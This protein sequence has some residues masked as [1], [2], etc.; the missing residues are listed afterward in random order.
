VSANGGTCA[1]IACTTTGFTGDAGSCTCAPNFYGQVTYTLFGTTVGC[2]QCPLGK[3]SSTA[4][5]GCTAIVCSGAFIGTA[6]A[7]TC[8]P[9]FAGAPTYTAGVLSGCT[10][11]VAGF[12]S[13]AGTNTN[14]VKISCPLP[15][16][17]DIYGGCQC[18]PGWSGVVAYV[19]GVAQGC[20]QCPTGYYAMQLGSFASCVAIACTGAYAGLAGACTCAAGFAGSATYLNGVAAGCTACPIGKWSVEGNGNTCTASLCAA[21]YS[22]VP[23]QCTCAAGYKGLASG[24]L[25]TY[26]GGLPTGCTA[27]AAGSW[28]LPTPVTTPAGGNVCKFIDCP[29]PAYDGNSG[30]CTCSAGFWGTV[31]WL[32]GAAT[33]CAACPLGYWSTAGAR[34]V[35]TAVVCGPG[36]VGS[37]GLCTCA[38]GYYGSVNYANGMTSGCT[39]C[40]IGTWSVAGSK[41]CSGV[42]C[43]A[44]AFSGLAGVCM[45]S[46]NYFGTVL[47][48]TT[49]G[50]TSGCKA[51]AANTYTV[52]GNGL[53]CLAVP[54]PAPAYTGSAGACT[55]SAGWSG[56]V[57]Y[58][59]GAV[60]GC[61][62]CPTGYWSQ[63]GNAQACGLIVCTAT[64]YTKATGQGL[65]TCAVGY[66]GVVSYLLGVPTGCTACAAGKWS[67]GNGAACT[68]VPCNNIDYIGTAGSCVCAN[69]QSG[70]AKTDATGVWTGCAACPVGWWSTAGNYQSCTPAPCT[71]GYSGVAGSCM[72]DNGLQGTSLFVN[73]QWTG[74]Q[75]CPTGFW[76]VPAATATCTAITCPAPGYTGVSGYC[77]CSTGYSGT[78]S[79][80]GG[81]ATG[82]ALVSG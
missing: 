63:P 4:S 50:T 68:P 69:G 31:V 37:D 67:N 7:C 73:G 40:P 61:S 18:A 43:L 17:T 25:V 34:S 26:T 32:N 71:A 81:V 58:L 21:A 33:G 22:G 19:N 76:S 15:A 54:C 41:T 3:Y 27:C 45:C 20:S 2:T 65:C 77:Q 5:N 80:V 30:S 57:A 62:A 36:Y 8:A 64:G 10:P 38:P 14:C 59:N 1:A 49:A 78:V 46:A 52:A 39:A 56:S 75:L 9:G 72:C 66:G 55:C 53:T 23:G 79:Y 13:V 29:S 82:C 12:W 48:S 44:P 42:A 74:C 35:C 28:M 60:L 11:C 24:L 6:G 16:F 70:V 47:Y 51:C